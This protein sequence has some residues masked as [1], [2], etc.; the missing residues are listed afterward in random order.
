[1]YKMENISY[2]G[3][4]LNLDNLSQYEVDHI[5]PRS[6]YIKDDSID[7]KAL[8]LKRRKSKGNQTLYY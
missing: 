4:T 7:N 8:V 6:A 2:S 5:I 1:M 3:K